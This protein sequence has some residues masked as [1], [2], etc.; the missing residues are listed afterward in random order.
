M[1][2]STAA[3]IDK[4]LKNVVTDGNGNKAFSEFTDNHG[5]TATAQSGW[6]DGER[7][8]THTW[9]CGY[10]HHNK[11]TYTAVILKEDGSSGAADCAPIFKE[12]SERI[13]ELI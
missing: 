3:E 9:F 2:K 13:A 1:S 11:T 5:K 8:I 10:F 4:F 6:F 7:E 12:M